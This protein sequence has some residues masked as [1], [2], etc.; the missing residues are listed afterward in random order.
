[1]SSFF[2]KAHRDDITIDQAIQCLEAE[3]GRPESEK[4]RLDADD[5]LPDSRVSATPAVRYGN[6]SSTGPSLSGTPSP[7]TSVEKKKKM[8]R[9]RRTN[10]AKGENS[11]DKTSQNSLERIINVN[12]CPLY[13]RP[14]L[15]SKAEI[16]VVTHLAI[17][18]SQDWNKA[19]CIVVGNFVTASQAEEMVYK[20]DYSDL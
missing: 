5:G 13:H 3:L 7:G 1:V 18:A 12:N 16:D 8:G 14:R 4:K 11:S 2:D 10:K 6:L 15:N 9:F 17:C 19:D 20:S